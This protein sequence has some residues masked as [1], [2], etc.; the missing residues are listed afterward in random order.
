MKR[1]LTGLS[2]LIL[3]G[4]C[5]NSS[6]NIVN[7]YTH[8]HYKADEEIYKQFTKTTGIKVNVIKSAADQLIG[9][10]EMEG[11]NT[12]ADVFITVDAGRLWRAKEKGLLQPVQSEVL[13]QN[14]PSFL[15]DK[16][17]YW[18]GFSYRSRIIAYNKEQVK[19]EQLST[20]DALTEEPWKAKFLPRSSES[21]YN[22]SLLAAFIAHHG[23]AKTEQWCKAMVANFA[24]VPKGNDT[25]II[26]ELAAGKG[27]IA[28]VNNYYVA[29]MLNS[30]VAEEKEAADKVG[31]FFPNQ[32]TTGA[33]I[34]ISGA[35]VVKHSKHKDNAVKLLEFLSEEYA[36]KTFTEMNYEYPANPNVAMCKTLAAFGTFKADT[37][38]LSLLGKFNTD[39]VKIFDRS[40]WY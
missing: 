14:I 8:R 16:E 17:N 35:A 37:L 33:H 11:A 36:Q 2:A 7:I 32:N 25:D 10:L 6:D 24:R 9:R 15:K 13:H 20:Y 40:G 27:A 22:Q 39:A 31:I 3:W 5:F 28:L 38:D 30:A 34:N 29:Q 1:L 19:P 4:G 26:K 23:E 18:F 12:P 21:L